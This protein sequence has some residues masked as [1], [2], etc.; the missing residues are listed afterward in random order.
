MGK[1]N[2]KIT[3]SILTLITGVILPLFTPQFAKAATATNGKILI[4]SEVDNREIYTVNADGSD[5]AQLTDSDAN[6]T[7]QAFSP[8]GQ[9]IL[10]LSDSGGDG[11][12]FIM[13]AD[14]SDQTQ[15]TNN[16]AEDSPI[17]FSP[18][19]S[20][21]LF[22][23]DR[24]GSSDIYMMDVDGSNQT[25]LTNNDATENVGVFDPDGESIIFKSDRDGDE[26]IYRVNIDGTGL[27]QLTSE[28]GADIPTAFSPDGSKILFQAYRDGAYEIGIMDADG[29]DQIQLTDNGTQNQPVGF[30]PDGSR[31]LY[32]STESGNQDVYTI[33]VDGTG[34]SQLTTDGD[35][36]YAFGYSPDGQQILFQAYRDDSMG[37][38][39]VMDVDGSD[40]HSI[41]ATFDYTD[42]SAYD[43]ARPWQQLVTPSSSISGGHTTTTIEEGESSS[44]FSDPSY[45]NYTVDDDE[46]LIVNGSLDSVTV[47]SGGTLKGSGEVTG[48]VTVQ[49]GGTI[50]PGQSPGCMSAGDLTLSSGSIFEAEIGGATACSQYDRIN[51][52]GLVNVTGATLSL[53]IL[54]AYQAANGS[55]FTLVSNDGSDSVIGTFSGLS[56]G[57]QVQAGGQTF[58]ISYR[59]GSGNDIVLSVGTASGGLP[60]LPNTGNR[61]SGILYASAGVLLTTGSVVL[62]FRR[63]RSHYSI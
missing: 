44:T 27:T 55:S 41:F 39:F 37:D 10:F 28:L 60:G 21:I 58:T 8:N 63:K 38:M 1:T 43:V 22:K 12:V 17:N 26:N 20:K 48:D 59:G 56:E 62:A 11:E 29:S 51:V 52:T 16:D 15:L 50:A 13:D 14:G 19:G 42:S 2:I 34:L 6:E 32:D 3:I 45:G 23:T 36:D 24:D 46:T 25:N 18:D 4:M 30:S 57:A 33:N 7:P 53:T 35:D 54:N 49:S 31:V 61:P 40:E 47:S 9:K 5:S